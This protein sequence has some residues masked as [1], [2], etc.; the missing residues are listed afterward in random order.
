MNCEIFII[1]IFAC[2][3]S[4]FIVKEIAFVYATMKWF[5]RLK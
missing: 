4:K 2:K 1:E 5:D 3:F